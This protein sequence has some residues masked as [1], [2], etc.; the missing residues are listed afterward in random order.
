MT[1]GT[2][3]L[4]ETSGLW[5]TGGAHQMEPLSLLISWVNPFTSRFINKTIFFC[6][7]L[8]SHECTCCLL[9]F[10]YFHWLSPLSVRETS[11]EN[12]SIY[13]SFS[14]KGWL[15]GLVWETQAPS[16]RFLIT[17]NVN[18]R[19]CKELRN[20]YSVARLLNSHS[21]TLPPTF[22]FS[23]FTVSWSHLSIFGSEQ[24]L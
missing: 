15:Q 6:N 13:K 14:G 11:R 24:F 9:S 17:D 2:P 20:S 22:G 18:L 23:L 16:D 8:E 10:L 5:I 21:S 7:A 1:G 19:E 3:L 4:I 12:R